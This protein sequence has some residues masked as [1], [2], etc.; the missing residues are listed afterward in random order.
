MLTVQVDLFS[1]SNTC[2][3]GISDH[4]H[5]VST[6][7]NKKVLKGSTKTILYRD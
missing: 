4:H 5:L 6:M 1:N 7:L 3:V 2:K